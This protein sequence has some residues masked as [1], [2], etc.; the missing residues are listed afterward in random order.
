MRWLSQHYAAAEVRAPRTASDLRGALAALPKA[1]AIHL[2]AH[3]ADDPEDPWRSG[4]LL[5]DPG[6]DESWLRPSALAAVRMR[7]RLAVL[8]GC[9]SASA[10]GTGLSAERGLASAFLASGTKAVVGTL[11]PVEDGASSEFVHRFYRALDEGRDAAG[12]VAQAQ[13]GMRASAAWRAPAQWAAFVLLGDPAVRLALPRRPFPG[14]SG[15]PGPA[16][17]GR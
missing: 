5:G 2:A 6:R 7:A 10:H 13:L 3:F 11:W 15:W 8:A 4:V 17:T 14:L 16:G 1:D 9:A 12:A